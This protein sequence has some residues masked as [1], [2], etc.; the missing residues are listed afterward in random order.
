MASHIDESSYENSD[1]SSDESLMIKETIEPQTEI[2]KRQ[3]ELTEEEKREKKRIEKCEK[4]RKRVKRIRKAYDKL[5]AR[6]NRTNR[7]VSSGISSKTTRNPS[8]IAVLTEALRYIKTLQQELQMHAAQRTAAAVSPG[9]GHV[10][11]D[12]SSGSSSC[13]SGQSSQYGLE[14]DVVESTGLLPMYGVTSDHQLEQVSYN[15]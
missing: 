3:E 15:F 7:M 1:E 8:R 14:C 13:S 12:I 6:I 9:H 2:N 10:A 11:A 5:R 4:E